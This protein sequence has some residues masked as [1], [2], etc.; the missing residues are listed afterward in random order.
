MLQLHHSVCDVFCAFQATK[1]KKVAK[2]VICIR[3]ELSVLSSRVSQTWYGK[4]MGRLS[5]AIWSWCDY[6]ST[7]RIFWNCRTNCKRTVA[8]TT[9]TALSKL[10]GA[11]F[12]PISNL[13]NLYRPKLDVNAVLS[14]WHLLISVSRKPVLAFSAENTTA[15]SELSIQSFIR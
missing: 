12:V 1:P 2:I 5:C 11:G 7:T 9:S 4:H 10:S 8:T 3:G 14:R 13:V 15:S 6:E